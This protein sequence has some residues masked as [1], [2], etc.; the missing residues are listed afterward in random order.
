MSNEMKYA[1][2]CDVTNKGMNDGY[3][4]QDG[5]M[6]IKY[7]KDLIKHLRK[8]EMHENKEEHYCSDDFLLKD[9]YDAGYYYWTEWED[10]D[11]DHYYLEDGTE[12]QTI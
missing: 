8:I 1:R 12:I 2:R 3:C 6:Y 10:I 7:E 9:Y 5:H 4:I 11:D